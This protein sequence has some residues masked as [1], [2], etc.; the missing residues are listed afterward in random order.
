RSKDSRFFILQ[1]TLKRQED[2][3]FEQMIVLLSSTIQWASIST[4]AERSFVSA[5]DLSLNEQLLS[6]SAIH[7]LYIGHPLL[8]DVTAP[9]IIAIA[10]RAEKILIRLSKDAN[11]T[12][13]IAFVA[14]LDSLSASTIKL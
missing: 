8:D 2:P 7:D 14:Q 11:L 13:P 9:S 4:S 1:V 12:D 5:E 6:A 10:S 3:A